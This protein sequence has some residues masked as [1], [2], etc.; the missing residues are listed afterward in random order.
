MLLNKNKSIEQQQ[1]MVRRLEEHIRAN[2]AKYQKEHGNY[3]NHGLW[4]G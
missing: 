3:R 1:T 2:S 4:Q